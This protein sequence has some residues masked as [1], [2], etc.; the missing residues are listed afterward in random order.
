MYDAQRLWNTSPCLALS[1][2]PPQHTHRTYAD[3]VEFFV[4]EQLKEAGVSDKVVQT[5]VESGE[6]K[7]PE[8]MYHIHYYPYLFRLGSASGLYWRYYDWYRRPYRW[9]SRYRPY[10]EHDLSIAH[11]S[12]KY[13]RYRSRY[14]R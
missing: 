6:R 13:Y 8:P 4:Y 12:Y 3:R 2:L 5:M 14:Y 7:S 9:R 10:Y 1:A 11:P